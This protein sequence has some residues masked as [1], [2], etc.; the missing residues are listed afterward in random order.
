M[1]GVAGILT[2]PCCLAP[3]LLSISGG[4]A[5]GLS[6]MLAS[7][8]TAFALTSGALLTASVWMNIHRQAPPWNKWLAAGCSAGAFWFVARGF[9]L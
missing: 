3:A 9:W 5:A 8:H 1:A 6:Q 4:S 2:R 7:H